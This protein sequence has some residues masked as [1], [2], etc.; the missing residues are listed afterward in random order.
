MKIKIYVNRNAAIAAGNEQYGWQI[1]DMPLEKIPIDLRAE[2][3]SCH[4][5]NGVTTI[6]D[7]IEGHSGG[8]D[9]RIEIAAATPDAAIAALRNRVAIRAHRTTVQARRD[10]E[11]AAEKQAQVRLIREWMANPESLRLAADHVAEDNCNLGHAI[12]KLVPAAPNSN[13]DYYGLSVPPGFDALVQK[14]RAAREAAAAESAAKR[15]AGE[16]ALRAWAEQHGS[17][18]LKL[19]LEM[20]A[21]DWLG[22][23]RREYM[24]SHAPEGYTYGS[25]GKNEREKPTLTELGELKRLRE[26]CEKSDGLLT[27]PKLY[28]VVEQSEYDHETGEQT[29]ERRY[30]TAEVRIHSPDGEWEYYDCRIES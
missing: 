18:R 3:A 1:I 28:W 24:D 17:E 21:G 7:T 13:L 4:E 22:V 15:D 10:A 14:A 6:D 26:S 30:C 12:Y 19:M 16:A 25:R 27:D 5:N 8:N 9:P 11:L 29:P 20:D 23:A 2:L